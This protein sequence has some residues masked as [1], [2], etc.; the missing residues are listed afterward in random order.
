V[1]K[2]DRKMGS[3]VRVK[4]ERIM[5]SKVEVKIRREGERGEKTSREEGIEE[6]QEGNN[7]GN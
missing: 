2:I 7:G 5:G 3:K 6:R 4:I 1:E